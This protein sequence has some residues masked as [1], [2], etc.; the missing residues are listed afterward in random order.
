MMVTTFNGSPRSTIIS[1]YT[2]T[3]ASDVTDLITFYNELSS[4]I[5]RISKH[6]VLIIN[7]DINAQKGKDENNKFCLHNS[8]NRNEEYLTEFSHEAF[9]LNFRKRRENFGFTPTQIMLKQR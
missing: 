9:V 8:S 4:L 2:P 6:N 3:D 7:G 5:R 1:C